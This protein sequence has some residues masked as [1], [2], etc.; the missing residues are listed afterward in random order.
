MKKSDQIFITKPNLP[1]LDEFL[2]YLKKI[3]KCRILT[4]DGE[5][6]Q[7]FEKELAE[8]LNLKYLS[9]F[10]NGTLALITALKSLN[11]T[12]EVI[13]T[14]YS[15]IATTHALLWNNIKPVFVDIESEKFNLNPD[16]IE[17]AITSRTTA[18]LPVHVYGN[19]CDVKKIKEIADKYGLKV[20]YDACHAFGVNIHGKS[21]L[22]FGDLSVLSFHATKVFSTFEGGAIVCHSAEMKRKIDYL[23]NHGFENETTIV[24]HGLN[25][26]M[27]E[28]QAALGILQLKYIDGNIEKRKNIAEY[29]RENLKKIKGIKFFSDIPGVRHSYSY[30][31]VLINKEYPLLRDKLYD[32]LKKYN[33]YSRRYFYP[34]ISEFPPYRN[35]ESAN[36]EN[37]MTAHNVSNQVLCLPMYPDLRKN[38]LDRIIYIIAV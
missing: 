15:F 4:N 28:F 26:K 25:A 13:T 9:L 20:I 23:K 36:K 5:F 8:Y 35:L 18:I 1:P 22:N 24:S 6:H 3:W 34:L 17:S 11:I 2:P 31:P 14:P 21:V 27:N 38:D 37:L 30:F 29:Y 12:G 32:K 10:C 33:I 16:K 7:R 19:P